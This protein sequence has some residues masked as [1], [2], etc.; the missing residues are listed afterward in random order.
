MKNEISDRID[1]TLDE[2]DAEYQANLKILE[3]IPVF[4]DYSNR[5]DARQIELLELEDKL[6]KEQ[7]NE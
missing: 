4:S 6:Y 5:L 7:N 1:L 3:G 2:I